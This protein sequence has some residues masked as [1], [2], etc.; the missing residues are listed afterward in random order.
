MFKT[1]VLVT[2]LLSILS[3]LIGLFIA[4]DARK[5]VL[6]STANGIIQLVLAISLFIDA[7]LCVFL[8]VMCFMKG[9][10]GV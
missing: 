4:F 5:G 7:T 1:L 8:L 3:C 9:F 10:L 6:S 2:S